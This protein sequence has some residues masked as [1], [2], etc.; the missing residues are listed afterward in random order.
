VIAFEQQIEV[1]DVAENETL[2]A[3]EYLRTRARFDGKRI[4]RVAGDEPALPTR[5]LSHGLTRS[6]LI[7]D[8]VDQFLM[9]FADAGVKLD[10][11]IVAEGGREFTVADMLAASKRNFRATQ[12][13]AWTLVAMSTYVPA[14]ASWTNASGETFDVERLTALAI[15]RDPRMETEG[16]P[17][18]LYAVAYA[19]RERGSE[20]GVWAD[21][22]AYL[23]KYAMTTRDWQQE[24]GA[25]SSR[26]LRGDAAPRDPKTLV[27]TTGH[28]LE[29]LALALPAD[30]LKTAWVRRA[31]LRLC[32]VMA[33]HPTGTFSDGG[34][35]H[36]AHGLRL[37][38]ESVTSAAD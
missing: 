27:S 37:Y 20:G 24:D 3:H 35:Y 34:L 29:W 30:E 31:V 7:Q 5:G 28:S 23:Q 16:G 15:A 13:L 2:A 19:L 9:A 25:F 12:E 17:H 6:F 21:A 18:H 38:R 14:G 1:L 26:M 4:F 22:R 10:S 36:A 11:P 33:E 8:H 32:T